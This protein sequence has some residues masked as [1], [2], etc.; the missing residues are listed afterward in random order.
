M[1]QPE[2]LLFELNQNNSPDI[3]PN[4]KS[5]NNHNFDQ[6]PNNIPEKNSDQP[7]DNIPVN[8]DP[9][10]DIP[11]IKSENNNN[12][13]Q[14]FDIT[15]S[16]NN[17]IIKS[18]NNSDPILKYSDIPQENNMELNIPKISNFR[19]YY[20]CQNCFFRTCSGKI[21]IFIICQK[22]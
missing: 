4:I 17:S 12:S 9:I 19:N 13:D 22:I 7:P 3:I 16:E 18:E 14:I 21:P 1:D 2:Y 6:L 5:E 20:L 10:L 8:S 11:K 15:I